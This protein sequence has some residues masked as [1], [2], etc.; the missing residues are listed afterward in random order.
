MRI[1]SCAPLPVG[2]S[3]FS[4]IV[5]LFRPEASVRLIYFSTKFQGSRPHIG[6]R[7]P[8]NANPGVCRNRMTCSWGRGNIQGIAC[9]VQMSPVPNLSCSAIRDRFLGT[10]PLKTGRIRTLPQFQPG[11]T[12]RIF[13]RTQRSTQTESV[14]L[15]TVRSKLR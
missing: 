3:K 9:C 12:M 11:Y 8:S 2:G 15:V 14:A 6:R 4:K 1:H 7:F 13:I 10:K 5:L